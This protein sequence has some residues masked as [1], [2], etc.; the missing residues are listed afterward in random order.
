MTFIVL[1]VAIPVGFGSALWALK[2]EPPVGAVRIGPWKSWPGM[3]SQPIDPYARAIVARSG[4][5]PLGS[6]EG[7][8]FVAD[9]DDSGA[10]LVA[11]CTYSVSGDSPAA[12]MWTLTLTDLGGVPITDEQGITHLTGAEVLRGADGRPTVTLSRAP[13]PGNWLRMPADGPVRLTLRLYDSPVSISSRTLEV[14]SLPSIQK[15]EC[16]Q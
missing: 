5:L 13:V 8:V 15:V 1:A 3:G 6:G 4:A 11:G 12:R 10:A 7:H 14:K 16:R 2:G 9:R